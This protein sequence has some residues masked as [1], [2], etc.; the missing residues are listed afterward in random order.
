M[1]TKA[2]ALCFHGCPPTVD[3]E[4]ELYDNYA[5]LAYKPRRNRSMLSIASPKPRYR[6]AAKATHAIMI[7]FQVTTK[8]NQ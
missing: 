7:R 3:A 1:K 4:S 2:L 5:A 8:A 6:P